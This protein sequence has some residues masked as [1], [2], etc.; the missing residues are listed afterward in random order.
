M[1]MNKDKTAG[2][3]AW[4]CLGTVLGLCG[5]SKLVHLIYLT[6]ITILIIVNLAQTPETTNKILSY[7][8]STEVVESNN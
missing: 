4:F 2:K 5:I 1:D 8:C 3:F 6:I 7:T